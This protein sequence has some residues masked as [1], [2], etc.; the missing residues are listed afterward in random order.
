[1]AA[2]TLNSAHTAKTSPLNNAELNR[3][4]YDAIHQISDAELD[5]DAYPLIYKREQTHSN[6]YDNWLPHFNPSERFRTLLLDR[7]LL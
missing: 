3:L 1:M 4:S 2:Y 5:T 6:D 7:L